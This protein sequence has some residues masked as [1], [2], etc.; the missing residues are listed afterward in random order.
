MIKI[1]KKN[2]FLAIFWSATSM[3]GILT[4]LQWKNIISKWCGPW[5]SCWK[6]KG[7]RQY[8][9]TFNHWTFLH[10]IY[11]LIFNIDTSTCISMKIYR[12]ISSL[13]YQYM[14]TDST[15]WKLLCLMNIT[16]KRIVRWIWIIFITYFS[17]YQYDNIHVIK[18]EGV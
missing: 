13:T 16:S 2:P 9:C 18:N 14:W 10:P 5:A 4:C 15:R 6:K 17:W 7:V 3:L 11:D 1:K 12:F 8:S